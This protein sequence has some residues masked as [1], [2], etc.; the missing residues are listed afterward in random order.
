VAPAVIPEIDTDL[1][2]G[3]G[4]VRGLIESSLVGGGCGEWV[5]SRPFK[6]LLLIPIARRSHQFGDKKFPGRLERNSRGTIEMKN[7]PDRPKF[8]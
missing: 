2:F 1:A 8:L 4:D 3:F 5:T 7:L 6:A